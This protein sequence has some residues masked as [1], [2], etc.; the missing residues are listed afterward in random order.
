MPDLIRARRSRPALLVRSVGM[1]AV[2]VLWLGAI[3]VGL[4]ALAALVV[5]LGVYLLVVLLVMVGL[6]KRGHR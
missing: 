4:T 3:A 6:A 5:A 2:P 1:M